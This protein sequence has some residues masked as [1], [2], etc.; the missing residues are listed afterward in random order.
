VGWSWLFA[1]ISAQIYFT[2]FAGMSNDSKIRYGV[3]LFNDLAYYFTMLLIYAALCILFLIQISPNIV[4]T[5]A[6]QFLIFIHFSS[7]LISTAVVFK[8]G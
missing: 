3:I 8:V 7:Y 2:P 5:L 1:R 4:E 6:V